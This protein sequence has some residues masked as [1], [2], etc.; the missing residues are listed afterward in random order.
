M[1]G[2]TVLQRTGSYSVAVKIPGTPSKRDYGT[3]LGFIS[4]FLFKFTI[5]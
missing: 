2:T 5:S 1:T 4:K 3:F